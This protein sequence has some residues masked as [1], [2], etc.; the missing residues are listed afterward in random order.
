MKSLSQLPSGIVLIHEGPPP[1][2]HGYE[3][4][5]V[6]HEC[7]VRRLEEYERILDGIECKTYGPQ[8]I[9][10]ALDSARR[11]IE[12]LESRIEGMVER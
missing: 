12:E 7:A 10:W 4:W 9:A 2:V 5:R 8:D 3:C 1:E 11:R 6:H